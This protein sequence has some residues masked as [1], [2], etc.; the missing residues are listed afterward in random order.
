MS[1]IIT[2][3]MRNFY[4]KGV[5]IFEMLIVIAIIGILVAIIAP[6]FS[7]LRDD[8]ILK[9]ADTAVYV[10]KEQG[11][12]QVTAFCSGSVIPIKRAA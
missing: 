3:I 7:K 9:N 11:R 2:L 10:S 4:Q 8:Q 6:Q 1:A 12:N 5:S